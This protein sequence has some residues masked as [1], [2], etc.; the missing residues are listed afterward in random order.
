MLLSTRRTYRRRKNDDFIVVRPITPLILRLFSFSG[1]TTSLLAFLVVVT[2]RLSVPAFLSERAIPSRYDNATVESQPVRRGWRSA[3]TAC[4]Y[5]QA[6][7]TNTCE[8]TMPSPPPA[9]S[10]QSV[11]NELTA[12]ASHARR[13]LDVA[14]SG[15]HSTRGLVVALMQSLV[16]EGFRTSVSWYLAPS[17]TDD[18]HEVIFSLRFGDETKDR[19]W[20]DRREIA[21]VLADAQQR[22]QGGEKVQVWSGNGHGVQRLVLTNE[23]GCPLQFVAPELRH[24]VGG[25]PLTQAAVGA[26]RSRPGQTG[27]EQGSAVEEPDDA[28]GRLPTEN[29]GALVP[30]GT[31]AMVS[32]APTPAPGLDAVMLGEAIQDALGRVQVEVDLGAMQ[33]LVA[34]ALRSALAGVTGG[35]MTPV[36]ESPATDTQW[37][38]SE[39]TAANADP[40]DVAR[41]VAASV[42]SPSEIAETL[43]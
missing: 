36:T 10:T 30:T 38:R 6:P 31:V 12:E 35:A 40:V 19:R 1:G 42:L 18:L 3:I 21:A 24:Y 27:A 39:P 43:L 28:Q 33:D 23:P 26:W 37:R 29:T 15:P 32:A 16:A 25:T 34:D 8:S 11:S 9:E 5:G 14:G 2:G 41:R 20:H 17:P 4:W 7:L 22:A 13:L